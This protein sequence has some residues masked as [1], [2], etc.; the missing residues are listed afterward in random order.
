M[1]E[2]GH[3]APAPH[4]IILKQVHTENTKVNLF[5][6][7]KQKARPEIIIQ[8]L[9]KVKNRLYLCKSNYKLQTKISI[10]R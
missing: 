6:G 1:L 2:L 4:S 8:T 9:A 7:G 5:Y 3:T 10:M